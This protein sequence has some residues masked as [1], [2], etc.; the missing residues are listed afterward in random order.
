MPG[1]P[2][3]CAYPSSH[4]SHPAP[5][6]HEAGAPDVAEEQPTRKLPS[7]GALPRLDQRPTQDQ[8]APP[9][10]STSETMVPGPEQ[11]PGPSAAEAHPGTEA[12]L[13]EQS[14]DEEVCGV[15]AAVE[16]SFLS[17]NPHPHPAPNPNPGPNPSPNPNEVW[18]V[19]AVERSVND[20]ESMGHWDA[21]LKVCTC[22]RHAHAHV[23]H[24]PSGT[25]RPQRVAC[26]SVC[27]PQPHP[28]P[29]RTLVTE[30]PSLP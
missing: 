7:S 24:A 28:H 18:L 21:L 10:G 19:L 12:R 13:S 5:N 11:L 29:Q 25:A 17:P 23:P 14:T 26:G 16:C 4:L 1:V 3:A 30:L 15:C 22:A 8:C 27:M 20:V 2:A 9:V 6:A